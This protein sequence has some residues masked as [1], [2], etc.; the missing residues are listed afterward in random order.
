[1]VTF[2]SVSQ[3]ILDNK[4]Q[5]ECCAEETGVSEMPVLHI[6]E[7]SSKS[8]VEREINTCCPLSRYLQ[9]TY[10]AINENCGE[11]AA[12]F[13]HLYISKAAGEEVEEVCQKMHNYPDIDSKICSNPIPVCSGCMFIQLHCCTRYHQKNTIERHRYGGAGWLAFGEELFLVPELTC[14]FTV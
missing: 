11:F 14:M 13:T 2:L 4:R 9:C 3:C 7:D 1:M 5:M 6:I 12:N 10:N 8:L